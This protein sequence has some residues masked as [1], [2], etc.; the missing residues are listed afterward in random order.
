MT[1]KPIDIAYGPHA[2]DYLADGVGKQRASQIDTTA[3]RIEADLAKLL[4]PDGTP[5]YGPAEHK[6]R[7][8]AIVAAYDQVAR[9]VYEQ[10]EKDEATA[11]QT[12]AALDGADPLDRLPQADLTRARD[13]RPFIAEEA[14]DL[15][16]NQLLTRL[17]GVMASGDQ[18]TRI[19]WARYAGKRWDTIIEGRQEGRPVRITDAESH[20]FR[21]LLD[22]LTAA[23]ADPTE[24]KRRE[25][26]VKTIATARALQHHINR[27]RGRL[28][29][30]DA[31]TRQQAARQVR[32]LF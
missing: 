5:V 25:A 2:P 18:A 27:T 22:Q 19:L 26:A 1:T 24:G 15:P 12:I 8:A 30:S 10:A 4:R 28:D 9:P 32:A 21:G 7:A 11:R 23:V 20:E 29:G 13:L 17:R 16:I 6:E 31:L 14:A 3:S